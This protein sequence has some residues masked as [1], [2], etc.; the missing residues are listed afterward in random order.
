MGVYQIGYG[1][2]RKTRYMMP[3]GHKAFVV[4]NVKEVELLLM[5]NRTHAAEYV[6]PFPSLGRRAYA[7]VKDEQPQR[8][9]RPS[10]EVEEQQTADI[11]SFFFLRFATELPTTS[12]RGS[13][14]TSLPVRSN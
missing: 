2:N 6:S 7:L 8:P 5:H 10:V 9:N 14:S 13:E 4:S 12:R 3:S 1:S 11:G